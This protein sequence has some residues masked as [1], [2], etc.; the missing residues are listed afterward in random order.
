MKERP[1]I[2]ELAKIAGVMDETVRNDVVLLLRMVLQQGYQLK[3]PLTMD[4]Y[5]RITK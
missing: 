3:Y 2:A 5:R 1:T 4:L